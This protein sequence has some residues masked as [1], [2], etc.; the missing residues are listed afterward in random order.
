MTNPAPTPAPTTLKPGVWLTK[1]ESTKHSGTNCA[2]PVEASA[3]SF[4]ARILHRSLLSRPFLVVPPT[5]MRSVLV[6]AEARAIFILEEIARC[7]KVH[8]FCN[9]RL[10]DTPENPFIACS[11]NASKC[12]RVLRLSSPCFLETFFNFLGVGV[13]KMAI[14]WCC[15]GLTKASLGVVSGVQYT[16]GPM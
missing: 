14:S 12:P 10:A 7:R 9:T 4:L 11:W 1:T 6:H 15:V 5:P 13:G 2:L 8:L 3:E 16:V